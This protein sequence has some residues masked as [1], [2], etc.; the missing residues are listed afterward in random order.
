MILFLFYMYLLIVRMLV[1]ILFNIVINKL[2][3]YMYF[4]IVIDFD[5]F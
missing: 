4:M 3:L 1:Y 2:N 5:Y